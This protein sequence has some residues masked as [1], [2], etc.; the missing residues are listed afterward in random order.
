VLT[1]AACSS[2][3]Q[4]GSSGGAGADNVAGSDTNGGAP[5]GGGSHAGTPAS[6]GSLVGGG[7][8][9]S[10]GSRSDGGSSADVTGPSCPDGTVA[11]IV[12]Q[13][14]PLPTADCAKF[15]ES[16]CPE[17]LN[18]CAHHACSKYLACACPCADNDLDCY[19]ACGFTSECDTCLMQVQ[20]CG[21]HPGTPCFPP[22]Q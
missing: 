16:A 6:G 14:F 9:A 2:S 5:V 12:K 13:E 3:G 4:P 21:I 7:A 11:L 17:K 15:V 10:G 19:A 8:P 20:E 18:E 1:V 22:M